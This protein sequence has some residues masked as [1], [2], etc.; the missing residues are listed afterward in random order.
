MNEV[1]EKKTGVTRLINGMSIPC[2]ATLN[3]DSTFDTELMAIIGETIR[4]GDGVFVYRYITKT[5]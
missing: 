2:D 1:I 5:I 4:H 3:T